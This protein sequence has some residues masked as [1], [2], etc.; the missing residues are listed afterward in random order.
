MI[1][2]SSASAAGLVSFVTGMWWKASF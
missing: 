1:D 2:M